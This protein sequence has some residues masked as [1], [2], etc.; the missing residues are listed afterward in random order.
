[1]KPARGSGVLTAFFLYRFD[2]WQEIDFEFL[3]KDTTK[4]LLN[5]F[6]NPGKEGDLYNYGYRGTPVIVD[7]GFDAADD[8]HRYAIEWE[9]GEI[10]W[11]A[12]DQLIHRRKSGRPTPVPHL[13]MRF[14]INV[15]PICSAELAGPL[16][17]TALPTGA[18]I[19]QV[20]LSEWQ[21]PAQSG[22]PPFLSEM[23]SKPEPAG[24]WR[25]GADW[26]QPRR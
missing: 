14:H 19:T 13:P 8:Y 5:V 6:Y 18:D 23:F 25:Q 20:S 10:R 24:D 7:L 15:W 2:P 16:D 12:D 11:F 4:A 22:L 17:T 1:M 3:G 26:I 21:P 9:P